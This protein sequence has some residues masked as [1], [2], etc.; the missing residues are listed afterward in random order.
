MRLNAKPFIENEFLLQVH[1]HVNQTDL[2]IKRFCTE[3][4]FE[5]EAH[6]NSEMTYSPV[7]IHK[8]EHMKQF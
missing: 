3:S 6:G 2:H 4:R 5:T 8:P 1:F 7:P